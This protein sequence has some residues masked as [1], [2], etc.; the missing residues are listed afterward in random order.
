MKCADA[1]TAASAVS[2]MAATVR[3]ILNMA[4]SS[5]AASAELPAADEDGTHPAYR[6]DVVVPGNWYHRCQLRVAECAA[7]SQDRIGLLQMAASGQSRNPSGRRR[8][9][10]F[11]RICVTPNAPAEVA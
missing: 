3:V 7:R 6:R 11:R 2:A 1:L 10:R 9:V 5:I 4:C 8:I